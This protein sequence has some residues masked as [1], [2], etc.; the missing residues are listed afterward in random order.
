M[1]SGEKGI[2]FNNIYRSGSHELQR[3]MADLDEKERKREDL[4]YKYD[5]FTE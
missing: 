4:K 2:E 3:G 1:G 5:V